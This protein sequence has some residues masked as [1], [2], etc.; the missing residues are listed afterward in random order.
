MPVILLILMAGC[1][2]PMNFSQPAPERL[3]VV[4][5][6]DVEYSQPGGVSL[7]FDASLPTGE[8]LA[9]VAIVVHG[10]GWVG[11]ERRRTVAPLLQPLA[12]AGFA[13]FSISYRLATDPLQFGVA[14]NDVE[15]AIRFV[16]SHAAE[17]RLDPER[18][19]LV[20]ESAG[21]HLAAMAALGGAE[22]TSVRGVVALYTPTDLVSLATT[23]T[24][25][26]EGIRRQLHGTFFAK[27][28]LARLEQLSPIG[29]VKVGMPPFLLI[30][31]DSDKLVPIAQST[32]MCRRMTEVGAACTM[33]T[34]A[35]VGHSVRFWED[36]PEVAERYKREMVE[37]LQ[38]QSASL[39]N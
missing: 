6:R 34:M 37:W 13:W 20:G 32:E 2:L 5:L 4:L 35:G 9:P 33:R 24:M 11:G 10:G 18:I 26:P 29:L 21:G 36:S 22:G 25:I 15:A 3:G 7:Q 38:G 14:V 39:V 19:F 27:L 8:G 1:L 28:I 30:H 17:Y 31:G 16:K 23:S 12:D